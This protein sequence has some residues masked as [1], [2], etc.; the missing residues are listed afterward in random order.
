[1]VVDLQTLPI[2]LALSCKLHH[3]ETLFTELIFTARPRFDLFRYWFLEQFTLVHK[4][5]EDI[6]KTNGISRTPFYTGSVLLNHFW[7][8]GSYYTSFFAWSSWCYQ[9]Y[10]RFSISEKSALL[11][12]WDFSPEPQAPILQVSMHMSR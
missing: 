10:W 8:C 11:Q 12:S 5:K 6:N 1:M 7:T 2:S 3:Y 9:E 4:W